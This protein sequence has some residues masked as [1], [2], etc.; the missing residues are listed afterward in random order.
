MPQMYQ[1]VFWA[2]FHSTESFDRVPM[3]G[4]TLN[5]RAPDIDPTKEGGVGFYELQNLLK[6]SDRVDDESEVPGP[7][8][9]ERVLASGDPESRSEPRMLD[10]RV[11][12]ARTYIYPK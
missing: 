7:D 12:R 3:A 6:A 5:I 4:E 10:V 1:G 11:E 2:C 8:I 9:M